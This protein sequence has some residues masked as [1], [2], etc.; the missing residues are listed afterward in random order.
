MP[1]NRVGTHRIGLA[2]LLLSACALLSLAASEAGRAEVSGACVAPPADLV[3][4]WA[5]ENDAAD[6]TGANPGNA[7]AAGFA[8][9][10]VGTAFDFDGDND[11]VSVPHSASLS[12]QQFT[13]EGWIETASLPGPFVGFIAQQSGSTDVFGYELGVNVPS[14]QLRLTL[15]G[16][17]GGGDLQNFGPDLRDGVFH[18]VAGTYDGLR[19][20][21]W[22]DGVRVG[23][24]VENE[25]VSYEAGA[26]FVIGRR[27]ALTI[28]GDWNGRIDELSFY[29]RALC[30]AEIRAIFLAGTAG[31]C[32]E[33]PVVACELFEDSFESTNTLAWSAQSP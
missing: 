18:H 33:G 15:N 3:S 10:Q 31:K 7:S 21:T 27:P 4:W 20:H 1:M 12:P 24:L 2:K 17:V 26:P 13:I 16:A 5:A 23:T 14:G 32:D 28:D 29:S 22:V 25:V 30:A 11:S 9:G 19:M 6:E 8:T